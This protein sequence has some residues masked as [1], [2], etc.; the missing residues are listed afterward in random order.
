MRAL[1]GF[2]V[3]MM[4]NQMKNIYIVFPEGAYKALSFSYD[5]G[6]VADRHLV[7]IFNEYGLKGTFHLNGSLI[8]KDERLPASE[9]ASLYKGHEIACHT[10]WHPTLARCPSEQI[11]QEL[12]NDRRI[13][14]ELAGY[15]VRGFSYPNG[16]YSKKIMELLPHLG[17]DYA[18]VVP[19]TG[20]FDL[21]ENLYELK[22]T[23]HHKEG[24]LE[25]GKKLLETQR[26][27]HLYLM[28]VWGHSFEFDRENNW[29]LMEEFAAL[30][31]GHRDIW[32]TSSIEYCDYMKCWQNLRF[33]S[34]CSLV[35][36][37]SAISVWLSVNGAIHEVPGGSSVQLG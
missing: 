25:L 11:V 31:S 10:A 34:D 27:Q 1:L 5:D 7:S 17:I 14:E 23:C 24:L 4:N 30:M 12:M 13:L 21:P 33:S 36:N 37:P 9:I 19:S 22:A 8:G 18:R 28:Y 32:Y 26:S 16:S 29:E 3:C 15:T 6:N 35:E 20:T 2:I